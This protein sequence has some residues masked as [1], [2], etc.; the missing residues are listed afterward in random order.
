MLFYET[1]KYNKRTYILVDGLQRGNSIKKYM[2]S[3]TEFFYDDS[4]SND[5]CSNTLELIKMND[6]K[7]YTVVRNI[8]SEFIKEQ[9]T[10]KNLQYYEV[11]KRITE[12]FSA[13]HEPIGGIIEIIKDFFEERQAL[14]NKIA[15]TI[16]SVIVYNGAENNL[17]E[18]FN[19]INSQVHH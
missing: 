17:P 19:R 6:V 2:T 15:G 16:I 14:Y 7:E 9:K 5:L 3:P 10:F 1:Y 11:A 18:I 8:L 12:R 4:I 13:G